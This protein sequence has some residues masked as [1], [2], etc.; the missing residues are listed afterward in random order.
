ME[1]RRGYK[2]TEIG[3]LPADWPVEPLERFLKQR[4]TYGV[5]KAGKFQSVGIPMLRGGDIAEGRIGSDHPLISV[6]KSSEYARTVLRQNDVV[7]AL[8]GY[9]GEAAVVPARLIGA[10]ISRAVGLLRTKAKLNPNFLVALLNSPSGRAE[11]LRPSAGSAQIVV[12]L[13]AL[14]KM[15]L[16][17][18]SLPEQR[19]I[20]VAL[21][22][23]D[24]TIAA[25]IKLLAKKRDL[26]TATMQRL[27]T[28]EKRLAGFSEQWSFA[29]LG[30]C[31]TAPPS[32]GI[33][34]PAVPHCDTLPRYIRITDI[35][36]E[37]DYL[38]DPLVGVKSHDP[39]YILKP[40]D[41]V[42]ARTGATTGKTYLY[43]P[44]DGQLVYAGFLILARPD[45]EKLVSKFL[46]A[47]TT[48]RSYWNWVKTV[49]L[50]SGQPGINGQQ[51][52]RLEIPLPPVDE[53]LAIAEVITAADQE[54]ALLKARIKK[55]Q[56]L[57]QAMM[58]A[59]LTGRVRLPLETV[60]DAGKELADA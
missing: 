34:A 5:V 18:P 1:I 53:Q 43:D 42:F 37:G 11:F 14:N 12:N 7:I 32:Y 33:N 48:T 31:L 26:R 41:I 55:T 35:T 10:N 40:G 9:P 52:A 2:Q 28:G 36:E 47:Y 4:A 17:V 24:A 59:L 13:S 51:F 20:A 8:V 50:R 30:D 15:R 3:V 16:P 58:Q 27:L 49:S 19:A 57:K 25:M 44:K 46:A 29:N 54:I 21:A 23:V 45:P 6:E 60:E 22:D 38:P 56:A 39:R